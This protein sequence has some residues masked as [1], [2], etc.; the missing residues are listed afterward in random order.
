MGLEIGFESLEDS[1][2]ELTLISEQSEKDEALDNQCS[3]K[4]LCESDYRVGVVRHFIRK[5]RW[6]IDIER[7]KVEKRRRS[8]FGHMLPAPKLNRNPKWQLPR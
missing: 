8:D 4:I 6:P 2:A 7:K 3:A 5:L 1:L